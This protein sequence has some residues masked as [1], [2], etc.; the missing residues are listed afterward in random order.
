ME[1]GVSSP[2]NQVL[3]SGRALMPRFG[4]RQATLA[5]WCKSFA[6]HVCRG[7]VTGADELDEG[8][9]PSGLVTFREM[10]MEV[11]K[12]STLLTSLRKG[13]N[14]DELAID[15]MSLACCARPTTDSD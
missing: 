11:V 10:S 2:S 9:D 7:G 3:V 15:C 6:A 13:S 1:L 14:K 4:R 12:R 8:A 5:R